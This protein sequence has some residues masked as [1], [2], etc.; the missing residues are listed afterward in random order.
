MPMV[1]SYFDDMLRP[2]PFAGEYDDQACCLYYRRQLN[3]CLAS[4]EDEETWVSLEVK[5][6]SHAGGQ[7]GRIGPSLT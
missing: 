5:R 1:A 3:R 7:T 6:K 2:L 4:K